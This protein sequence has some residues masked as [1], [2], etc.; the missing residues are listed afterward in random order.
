MYFLY[1]V[2]MY[3]GACRTIADFDFNVELAS[4]PRIS[5]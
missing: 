5:I 4:V 2:E 3:E 1:Q